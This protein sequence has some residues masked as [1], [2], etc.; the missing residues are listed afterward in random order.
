MK[1]EEIIKVLEEFKVF[2]KT[3]D[4]NVEIN[5]AI[6]THAY[7]LYR[8][9]EQVAFR[10]L[11]L[12]QKEQEG[13]TLLSEK[14]YNS[15]QNQNRDNPIV[16]YRTVENKKEQEGNA[17]MYCAV[18]ALAELNKGDIENA[19]FIL[20][21][22]THKNGAEDYMREQQKYKEQEGMSAE[23]WEREFD[24]NF[25][26]QPTTSIKF[27]K[28]G[29]KWY[30]EQYAASFPRISEGEGCNTTKI[31]S[32][33]DDLAGE[34]YAT[35]CCQWGPITHENYCPNCGKKIIRTT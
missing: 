31:I 8:A 9:R 22:V 32:Q 19:K 15:P 1:R 3:L 25:G 7:A 20:E 30:L 23:E 35:Q 17:E 21:K 24:R 26:S 33:S 14:Q 13:I 28:Q 11:S 6:D 16:G 4:D 29:I 2:E 18:D 27:R 12:H 10:I 34:I 5:T